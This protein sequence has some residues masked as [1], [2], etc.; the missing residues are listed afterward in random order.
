MNQQ[1]ASQPVILTVY[2]VIGCREIGRERALPKQHMLR[3]S[4]GNVVLRTGQILL[5]LHEWLK[6]VTDSRRT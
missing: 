2:Q 1:S 4:V 6:T 3:Y 5:T